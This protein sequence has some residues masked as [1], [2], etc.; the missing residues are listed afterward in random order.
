MIHPSVVEN[1][2][3]SFRILSD[4]QVWEIK[5]AAF[6]VL[7]KVGCQPEEAVFLDDF[8]ENVAG[9]RQVGLH[10]VWFKNPEQ[11]LADLHKILENE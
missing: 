6:E 10:A 7:E 4:D 2:S 11:G 3:V 5:Q 1:K 8:K 9:A